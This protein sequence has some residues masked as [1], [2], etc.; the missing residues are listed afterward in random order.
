MTILQELKHTI[1]EKNI[2][3]K[4]GITY[5]ALFGSYA[6]GENTS[7]SDIDLYNKFDPSRKVSLFDLSRLKNELESTTNKKYDLVTKINKYVE[8]YIRQ[9]LITLYGKE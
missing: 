2:S 7:Q 9:D 4:Y 1:E 5:I 8:P 6:R 3:Q